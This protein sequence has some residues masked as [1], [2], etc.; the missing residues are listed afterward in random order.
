MCNIFTI[1]WLERAYKYTKEMIV[2]VYIR[3]QLGRLFILSFTLKIS[4]NE[5]FAVSHVIK[6]CVIVA[7][8]RS[9]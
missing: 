5:P 7:N 1:E 2:Y 9:N 4:S 3:I 8:Y 6:K